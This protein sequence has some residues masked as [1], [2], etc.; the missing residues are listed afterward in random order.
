M[1]YC[2]RSWI[3]TGVYLLLVTKEKQVFLWIIFT[4]EQ[5]VHKRP[6][7]SLDCRTKW[8]QRLT[9]TNTQEPCRRALIQFMLKWELGFVLWRGRTGSL[10]KSGSNVPVE[11][12]YCP[13]LEMTFRKISCFLGQSSLFYLFWLLIVTQTFL[14]LRW[15]IWKLNPAVL[16]SKY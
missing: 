1:C 15:L 2:H 4:L 9:H 11:G 10:E 13:S 3:L 8:S 14:E 16:I 12:I 6:K 7:H 5:V